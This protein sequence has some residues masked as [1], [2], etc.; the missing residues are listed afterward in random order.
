MSV[1][2]CVILW[3]FKMVCDSMINK[4]ISTAK[5]VYLRPQRKNVVVLLWLD[6]VIKRNMYE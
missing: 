6:T 5:L 2:V 4:K 3:T 1:N